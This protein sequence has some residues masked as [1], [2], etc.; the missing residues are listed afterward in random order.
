VTGSG[1][2]R[3]RI[4]KVRYGEVQ[5]LRRR[6]RKYRRALEKQGYVTRT[7]IDDSG[8]FALV[9]VEE[10]ASGRTGVLQADGSVVWLDQARGVGAL[11][12]AAVSGASIE[13]P[14]GS[15]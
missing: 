4:R 11:A 13:P 12:A 9:M 2:V 10:K 8:C 6:E 3:I 14:K 7:L 15:R 5:E 1:G